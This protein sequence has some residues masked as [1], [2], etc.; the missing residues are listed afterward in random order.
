MP[1][2]NNNYFSAKGNVTAAL[3]NSMFR[4]HLILENQDVLCTLSGKIK[5]NNIR[6]LEGDL[7]TVDVSVHD[8]KKGRIS[9][10]FNKKNEN[11]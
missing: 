9:Y 5:K 7:V 10:R 3:G 4:V 11:N 6:I 2:D 8:T 1:I